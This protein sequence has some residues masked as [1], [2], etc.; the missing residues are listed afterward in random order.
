MT[1]VDSVNGRSSA[2]SRIAPESDSENQPLKRVLKNGLLKW[3]LDSSP[4]TGN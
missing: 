2:A 1:T 4:E 3:L